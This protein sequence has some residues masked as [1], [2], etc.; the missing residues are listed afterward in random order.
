MD[1]DRLQHR[2]LGADRLAAL[3]LGGGEVVLGL[4]GHPELGAG[5]EEAGE[6][7]GG[8]GG[9]AALAAEDLAQAV[10]RDTHQE[11]GAVWG[12]VA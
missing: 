8:V 6:A 3:L 4:K 7:E 2:H 11:G 1:S 9:D 5:A 10:R 12:D